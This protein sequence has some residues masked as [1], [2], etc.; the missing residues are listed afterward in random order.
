MHSNTLQIKTSSDAT[1]TLLTV[2]MKPI[3]QIFLLLLVDVVIQGTN[4]LRQG[5]VANL[6]ID[7]HKIV[8]HKGNKSP[9]EKTKLGGNWTV[10]S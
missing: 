2:D 8:A 9:D 3:K 7:I 4:F 1:A 5:A 10:K 6:N